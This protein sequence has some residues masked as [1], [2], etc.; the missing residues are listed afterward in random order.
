MN[1]NFFYFHSIFHFLS[2]LYQRR[3]KKERKFRKKIEQDLEK[4]QQQREILRELQRQEQDHSNREHQLASIRS[5]KSPTPTKNVASPVI[6]SPV[7]ISNESVQ[8]PMGE[9]TSE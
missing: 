2:V 5:S 7:V 6:S 4:L 8:E 3:F 1:I 9:V